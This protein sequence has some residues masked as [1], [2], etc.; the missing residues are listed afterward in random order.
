[1]HVSEQP[2]S[3]NVIQFSGDRLDNDSQFDLHKNI[4]VP[5]YD[6]GA[7]AR[8]HSI[9]AARQARDAAIAAEEKARVSEVEFRGA[10]LTRLAAV[11][12]A[13]KNGQIRLP[14]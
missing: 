6:S 1:M 3:S 10:D 12:E 11:R 4:T 14:A 9:E 7:I 8:V 5:K 2:V 13:A